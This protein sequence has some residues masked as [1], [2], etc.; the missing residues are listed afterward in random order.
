MTLDPG[1]AF[2]NSACT[3]LMF[4][5]FIHFLERLISFQEQSYCRANQEGCKQVSTL[6][7]VLSVNRCRHYLALECLQAQIGWWQS[8]SV[9]PTVLFHDY[10]HNG[11][12]SRI[13]WL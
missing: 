2:K 12:Q 4:S 10:T 11:T 1:E 5:M 6:S 9:V 8:T 3:Q 7:K 13:M